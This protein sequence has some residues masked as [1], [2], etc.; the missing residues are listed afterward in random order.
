MSKQKILVLVK[1]LYLLNKT[2]LKV[3]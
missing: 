1:I 3:I 2:Y